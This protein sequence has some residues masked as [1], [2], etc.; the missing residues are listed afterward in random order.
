MHAV[1]DLAAFARGRDQRP[2]A[3]G[4]DIGA[5]C[6]AAGCHG[7]DSI[8]HCATS[9]SSV[10]AR[11]NEARRRSLTL[12]RSS[13]AA[14]RAWSCPAGH[15]GFKVRLSVAKR[16]LR[17]VRVADYGIDVFWL[18]TRFR[19]VWIDIRSPRR[20]DPRLADAA[21]RIARRGRSRFAVLPSQSCSWRYTF[22][23]AGPCC[24]S[25]THGSGCKTVVRSP[26][27]T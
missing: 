15:N 22:P 19:H 17:L 14:C 7:G 4:R 26:P 13:P 1:R 21:A 6:S 24:I 3:A 9:S 27:A 23:S 11:W 18:D 10:A 8:T 25:L 2:S 16:F 5:T 12:P 20:I